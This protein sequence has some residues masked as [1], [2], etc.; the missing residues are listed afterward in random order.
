MTKVRSLGFDSSAE[1]GWDLRKTRR[2]DGDNLHAYFV[3]QA[4][5]VTSGHRKEGKRRGGRTPMQLLADAVDTYR[6]EDVAR[7]WQ[8]ESAA[9]GRRQLEWSR[10]ERSLRSF[11]ELGKNQTDEEVADE[12]L[13]GDER[14]ALAPMTWQWLRCH[15]QAVALLSVA[16]T[17]GLNGARR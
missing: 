6:A 1:H 2:G 17:E 3:K 11:A 8:W 16:E 13:D 4:H 5:E 15:E 14:L 7:W 12:T 9:E 10:G